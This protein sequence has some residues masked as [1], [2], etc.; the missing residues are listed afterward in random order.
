MSAT[1]GRPATA[2][3]AGSRPLGGR[4]RPAEGGGRGEAGGG[5]GTRDGGADVVFEGSGN[6]ARLSLALR[7]PRRKGRVV[8]LGSPRGAAS[9]DLHNEVHSLGLRIIGAHNN[10]H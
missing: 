5:G 3:W 1:R 6:P 9:L 10:T 2:P 7:L 4:R 8:I